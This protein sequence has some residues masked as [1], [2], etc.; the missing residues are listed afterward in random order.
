M[1]ASIGDTAARVFAAQ[2]YS[3]IGFGHSVAK[4]FQQAKAA[5]MLEGIPEDHTPELFTAEGV[6]AST[7]F[8]VQLPG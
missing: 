7:L 4:A 3:A 6:D 2:F 5:L 8:L 1:N